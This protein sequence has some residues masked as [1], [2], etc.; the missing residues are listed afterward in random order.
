MKAVL[1]HLAFLAA[2]VSAQSTACA[3]D[4]IVEA[5]L[6]TANGQLADC[7]NNDYG[8]QCAAYTNMLT[9]FNNCPNDTRIPTYQAQKTT[10]CGLASQYSSS[11][12]S[13]FSAPETTTTSAATTTTDATATDATSTSTTSTGSAASAS[14]TN[15]A[16]DLALNAGG[17][18]AAVAGVVAAVL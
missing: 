12:S 1:F 18:L 3:A 8:C 14:K 17:I 15:S 9:C 5:C 7:N 2:A 16:A 11:T 4:Y 6:G 10:Y 13:A